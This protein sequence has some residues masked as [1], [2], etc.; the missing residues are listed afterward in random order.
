MAMIWNTKE[1]NAKGEIYWKK[2]SLVNAMKVKD[3]KASTLIPIIEQ[4]FV[5]EGSTIVTDELSAYHSIERNI[6]MCL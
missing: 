5:M 3:A 4:F 2:H 6:I 1:I